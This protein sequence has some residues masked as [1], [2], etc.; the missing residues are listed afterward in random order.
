VQVTELGILSKVTVTTPWALVV[1]WKVSC[2][3]MC[4][5]SAKSLT[6]AESLRLLLRQASPTTLRRVE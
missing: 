3:T 6:L 4:E 2:M 5:S 1:T